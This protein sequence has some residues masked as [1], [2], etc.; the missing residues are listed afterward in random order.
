MFPSRETAEALLEEALP[1]N[2]G[3]WGDHSRTAAHCA[4][5]IAKA[6]HGEC[7]ASKSGCWM[8]SVAMA[9]TRSTSGTSM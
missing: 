9:L 3:P 4:E 1:H 5:C 6:S 8:S 2:P 7:W